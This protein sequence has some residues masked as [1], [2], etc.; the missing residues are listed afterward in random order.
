MFL[1]TKPIKLSFAHFMLATTAC[2][3]PSIAASLQVSPVVIDVE[4]EKAS[5]SVITLRNTGEQGVNAQIRVFRWSQV[6]GKDIYEETSDVVAS[7]PMMKLDAKM[8]NIVRVV[9]V[10]QSAPKGEESYRLVIDELPSGEKKAG[11][12]TLLVRHAIPVFFASSK[13]TS[14]N[15]N[16]SL[17]RQNGRLLLQAVNSGD[18]RLRLANMTANSDKTKVDFGKGLNGYVLGHSNLTLLSK[19]SAADISG[20]VTLKAD[21]HKEPLNV[22]VQIR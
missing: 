22:S 15:I 12:I 8:S 2:V 20:A 11:T 4:T 16:W 5:A 21:T 9:R 18:K 17:Q 3:S 10:K 13:A 14:E 6:K 19:T 7:P 1:L